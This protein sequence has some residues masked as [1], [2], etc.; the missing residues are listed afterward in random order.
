MNDTITDAVQDLA[1]ARD[2]LV[3]VFG[4]TPD[5]RI[6]WTPA[7]T[8]RTAVQLVAHCAFAL[9]FIR[10]M[11]CGTPYPAKTM[12]QADAEFL[13]AERQ[14][15]TREEVMDMFESNFKAYVS[16]LEGF[17][18]DQLNAMIEAPFG[19]GSVPLSFAVTFG[20]MHTRNHIAQLEYLQ[21]IYGD[22]NW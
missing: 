19:L 5:D 20:A 3:R 7:P 17:T 10:Q 13:L 14:F 15:S 22:R 21:T 1:Q 8:A 4:N 11:L 18:L 9:D 16:E 2:Q 6:N 12:A